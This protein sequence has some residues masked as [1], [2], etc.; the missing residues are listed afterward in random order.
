MREIEVVL[1]HEV[2]HHVYHHLTKMIL[3]GLIY[4]TLSFF[5]CD[6]VLVSWVTA[7]EGSFRYADC[8]VHA[9]AMIMFVVTAVFVGA[10]SAA[11]WSEPTF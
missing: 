1:A 3:L 11:Q 6:W 2:G 7:I 5:V 8:P 10:Q 9:L 4:T